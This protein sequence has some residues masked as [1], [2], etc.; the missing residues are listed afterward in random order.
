[1]I[2][3]VI[4]HFN[5]LW[6]EIMPSDLAPIWQAIVTFQQVAIPPPPKNMVHKKMLSL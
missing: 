4:F 6:Y 3:L 1:M 5:M 2:I